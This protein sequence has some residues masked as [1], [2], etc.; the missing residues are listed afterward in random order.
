MRKPEDDNPAAVAAAADVLAGVRERHQ[1]MLAMQAA[2]LAD[3]VAWADL[4]LLQTPVEVPEVSGPGPRGTEGVLFLA[5]P[6]AHGVEEFAVCD[7]A[8]TLGMSERAARMYV[9][10]ALELRDRLPRLYAAVLSGVLPVWRARQIARQTRTLSPDTA[11]YVDAHLAPFVHKVNGTRVTR[12]VEAALLH[13]DPE[14]AKR[15]AAEAAERRHVS[16]EDHLGGIS[17]LT[18]ILRTPDAVALEQR[19]FIV[20]EWLALLGDTDTL[21]VRQSKALALLADPQAALD[22]EQQ[23]WDHVRAQ[24]AAAEDAPVEEDE[25]PVV[26]RREPASGVSRPTT[27]EKPGGP[28]FHLH[29]HLSQAAVSGLSPVVR[30]ECPGRRLAAPLAAVEQWLAEVAPGTKIHVTPVVDANEHI[31]VDRYEVPPGLARQV[32]ETQHV[33]AFPYCGRRGRYDLDHVIEY[34]DPDEG[35]PPGQTSSTNMARLC[36]FHHRVK[37]HTTWTPSRLPDGAL[38]WTSPTGATYRVDPTGTTRR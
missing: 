21:N 33:C 31:A 20:A 24:K 2:E 34:L 32:D 7:L 9:G 12:A 13:C 10:E 26:E 5:G 1:S 16:V 38:V 6:G 29:V 15:R 36:R 25:A 30:V 17:T 23:A 22:F 14:A 3:V 8:T 11:A 4:H 18:A 27:T 37:T 35:G 28:V 19:V